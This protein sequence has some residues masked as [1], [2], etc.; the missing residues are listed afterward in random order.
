MD[1]WL[2]S[3]HSTI[4]RIEISTKQ[5]QKSFRRKLTFAWNNLYRM[6][7]FLKKLLEIPYTETSFM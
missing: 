2:I 7:I 4:F 6:Q 5:Q 3:L 1:S